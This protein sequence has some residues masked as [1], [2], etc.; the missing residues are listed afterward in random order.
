[1]KNEENEEVLVEEN[2]SEEGEE[3]QEEGDDQE[4][5]GGDENE[6]VEVSETMDEKNEEKINTVEIKPKRKYNRKKK[7]NYNLKYFI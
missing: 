2:T 5:G 1:M 4:E 6:I 7:I 3:E